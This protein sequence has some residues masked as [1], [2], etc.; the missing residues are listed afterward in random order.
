MIHVI[1][2]VKLKSGFRRA[3]L[4]VLLGNVDNVKAEAGCLAYEPTIDI[5]TDIPIHEKAG[6]DTVVIIEAWESVDA[7][8]NHFQEP[9]MLSYR[10]KVKDMFDNVS[11]KVLKP[12]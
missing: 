11:I 10:E 4:D 3:Y 6:D 2:A 7:L 5:E 8:K 12:A 9:H 1:A